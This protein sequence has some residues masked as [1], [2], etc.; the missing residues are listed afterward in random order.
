MLKNHLKAT[1]H[2]ESFAFKPDIVKACGQE[3]CNSIPNQE[4]NIYTNFVRA[5]I[6]TFWNTEGLFENSVSFS[7][8]FS[9]KCI[10]STQMNQSDHM[11]HEHLNILLDPREFWSTESELSNS[12][13]HF[14][15]RT[16][17]KRYDKFNFIDEQGDLHAITDFNFSE[18]FEQFPGAVVLD[19]NLSLQNPYGEIDCI[20]LKE[21]IEKRSALF[22]IFMLCK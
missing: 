17:S 13:D 9:K 8:K 5:G 10:I 22:I 3:F 14:G 16:K 15:F 4:L 11:Q 7:R 12:R 2:C 6:K 20:C 21:L 1:S 18:P 19:N